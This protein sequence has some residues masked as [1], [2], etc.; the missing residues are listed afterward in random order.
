M[1]MKDKILHFCCCLLITLLLGWQ[2][3]ATA[4]VTKEV[5]DEMHYRQYSVGN[6][7]DW[8]DVLADIAGIA[9]GIIIRLIFNF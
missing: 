8:M 5:A 2:A 6:G 4:A 1:K 9:I 3:G 7:W